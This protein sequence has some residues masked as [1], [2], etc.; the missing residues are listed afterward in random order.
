MAQL[1]DKL[2][3]PIILVYFAVIYI[4]LLSICILVAT[5]GP[6]IV[7]SLIARRKNSP[8]FFNFTETLPLYLQTAKEELNISAEVLTYVFASNI[9]IFSMALVIGFFILKKKLWARNTMIFLVLFLILQP[10]ILVVITGAS[11]SDFLNIE[12]I[13]EPIFFLIVIY[14]LTRKSVK[15]IFIKKADI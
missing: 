7:V 3:K 10:I 15:E 1:I 6:P 8:L 13:A 9:V 2:K 5:I 4:W 12:A 14:I 11:Y